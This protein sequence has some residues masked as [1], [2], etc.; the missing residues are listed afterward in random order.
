MFQKLF[1]PFCV[2]LTILSAS[3]VWAIPDQASL[4]QST[5]KPEP[6]KF[7]KKSSLGGIKFEMTEQQLQRLYGKP[8]KRKVSQTLQCGELPVTQIFYTYKNINVELTEVNKIGLVTIA[9]TTNRRYL[10]HKGIRVGDSIKKA[11]AAHPD[12]SR[13]GVSNSWTS[14]DFFYLMKTNNRGIITRLYLGYNIC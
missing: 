14:E 2:A 9:E 4:L 7:Y 1:S 5:P 6:E 10:T 12:L 8:L 3:S 11:Q 13:F